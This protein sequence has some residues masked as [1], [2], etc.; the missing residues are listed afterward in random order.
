MSSRKPVRKARKKALLFHEEVGCLQSSAWKS[1]TAIFFSAF[2]HS[3]PFF[4][5]RG[6]K[7]VMLCAV[8]E[9]GEITVLVGNDL[10]KMDWKP[11]PAG[12]FCVNTDNKGVRSGELTLTNFP[13]TIILKPSRQNVF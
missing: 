13:K 9:F 8:T 5:F 3:I 1:G 7:K 4:A 12:N 6:G 10:V 11:I 2:P